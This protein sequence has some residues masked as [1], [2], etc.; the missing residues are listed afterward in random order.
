MRKNNDDLDRTGLYLQIKPLAGGGMTKTFRQR[1][2]IED[3]NVDLEVGHFTDI[4]LSDA[5][6][7][8]AINLQD[9]D[10]GRDPR[11]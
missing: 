3:K 4:N 9:V 10:E 1:I 11:N 8:A 5:L 2:R 7:M 6:E